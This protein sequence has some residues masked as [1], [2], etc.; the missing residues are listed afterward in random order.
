MGNPFAARVSRTGT[1]SLSE[2]EQFVVRLRALGASDEEIATVRSTWDDLEDGWTEAD[3]TSLTLLPDDELRAELIATRDEYVHDTTDTVQ[4]EAIDATTFAAQVA[5]EAGEVVK[6][7]VGL[8]LE[9][10]GE[11]VGRAIAI[12]D[13]ELGDHG[14]KRTTLV[15]PLRAL[16]DPPDDGGVPV[17][18]VGDRATE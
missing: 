14:G 4:Q 1:E 18:Y 6:R 8:V 17:T 12:L 16:I 5:A 10:V 2:L 7:N 3:R 13:L 11:D 9:W 15:E